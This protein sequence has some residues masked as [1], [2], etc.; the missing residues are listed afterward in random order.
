MPQGAWIPWII[1]RELVLSF[2]LAACSNLGRARVYAT[3]RPKLFYIW[4]HAKKVMG[5]AALR[6]DL[7]SQK[8]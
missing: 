4:A 5:Q 2:P 7:R 8:S 1:V 6:S 3:I